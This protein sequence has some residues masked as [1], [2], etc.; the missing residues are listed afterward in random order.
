MIYRKSTQRAAYN[1]TLY[2]VIGSSLKLDNGSLDHP[3]H[4]VSLK[5]MGGVGD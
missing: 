3:A 2:S 4:A 5:Q 1:G